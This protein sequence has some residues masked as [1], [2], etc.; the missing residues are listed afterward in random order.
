MAKHSRR[1]AHHGQDKHKEDTRVPPSVGGFGRKRR[2][3]AEIAYLRQKQREDIEKRKKKGVELT[4]DQKKLERKEKRAEKREKDSDTASIKLEAGRKYPHLQRIQTLD[5]QQK[6]ILRNWGKKQPVEKWEEPRAA[7]D[8]RHVLQHAGRK[9]PPEHPL[10]KHATNRLRKDIDKKEKK[11][12]LEKAG[13]KFLKH[14]MKEGLPEHPTE[15]AGNSFLQ[16]MLSQSPEEILAG[17]GQYQDQDYPQE[18]S[19][20]Y[21]TYPNVSKKKINRQ[22]ADA[23]KRTR[24]QATA[25]GQ[26]FQDLPSYL[27]STAVHNQGQQPTPDQ[28]A[29]SEY[30]SNMY[31]N[32]AQQGQQGQQGQQLL[33]QQFQQG[34]QPQQR[35]NGGQGLTGRPLQNA[36]A[37]EAP[38]MRQFYEE[39][40]PSLANRFQSMG[41]MDSSG[42]N[43]SLGK[44]GAGLHE[45]LAALKEQMISKLRDQQ[46]QASNIGLGYAQLPMQKYGLQQQN[47]NIGLAYNQLPNQ[48]AALRQ[49]AVNMAVPY[50]QLPAQRWQQQLQA[51][52]AGMMASLYPQQ[53]Q[54]E[55]NRYAANADFAREQQIMNNPKWGNLVIAPKGQNASS[56]PGRVAGGLMGALTGAAAGGSIG[57]GVGAGIGGLA[58]LGAGLMGGS[59]AIPPVNLKMPNPINTTQR[60]MGEPINDLG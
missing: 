13:R 21:P 35:A 47:A 17:H 55:M 12:S 40:I 39:T 54:Q 5:K 32:K 19:R 38:Y 4:H 56:I 22:V 44:A 25:Q 48:R 1:H 46:L 53:Q 27:K 59:E 2:K 41:A 26:P 3:E 28:I 45:N 51:A 18:P 8:I 11:S 23:T 43:L 60:Q 14:G 49:Q 52:P 6:D 30:F 16:R 7:R 24:Q 15:R 37:F 20:S 36:L 10:E 58:G 42:F 34:Q 29:N 50:T 33:Q 9:G 31:G 57:G